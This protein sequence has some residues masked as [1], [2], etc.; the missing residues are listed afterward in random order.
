[1]RGAGPL[2]AALAIALLGLAAGA[3]Q[4]GLFDD[5]EARKAIID[6][7]ERMAASEAQH[8]AR[9]AELASN[10]ALMAEQLAALRRSVLELNNQIEAMRTEVARLRGNDEQVMRELSEMQRRQK[11]ATQALDERLGKMEPVKV[12]LDGREF[13]AERAEKAAYDEAMATLRSGDFDKAVT[14]F[15]AFQR[16]YPTS[17]YAN[18]TRFWLGNA[19]YGKRDYKEAISAFRAFVS[20]APDHPQAP[21]ALLALANSQAEMKDVK[22]ARRTIEE[23]MKTYPQS[24]AAQAGKQRLASIK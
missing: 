3:A 11:D 4:A 24:E 8:K 10:N 14:Q 16:R 22:G 21:E 20:A 19:L 12:T 7:R 2:R 23:L 5:D 6:L 9:A 17:G 13:V 15:G 1:M 18:S